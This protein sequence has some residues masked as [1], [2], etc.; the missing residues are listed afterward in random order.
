MLL[1]LAV[2]TLSFA[3]F[4]IYGETSNCIILY[5]VDNEVINTY[6]KNNNEKCY[7]TNTIAEFA[8]ISLIVL[9]LQLN[10]CREQ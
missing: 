5:P 6:G 7:L 3:L 1:K 8:A 9:K 2:A 4:G 10:E